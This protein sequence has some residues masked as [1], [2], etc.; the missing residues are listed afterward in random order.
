VAVGRTVAASWVYD[1]TSWLRSENGRAHLLADGQQVRTTNV[2][3]LGV[4]VTHSGITDAAGNEDPFVLAYGS[5]A[6]Q[7]FRNGVVEHGR[8]S[9]PSVSDDYTFTSTTGGA[10][11]LS[12]GPTWIELVPDSGPLSPG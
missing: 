11:T 3:V 9:R 1:G 7:V 6:A 12:P 10:L 4:K 8:W 5:G 2:V